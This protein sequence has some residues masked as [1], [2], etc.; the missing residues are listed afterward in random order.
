M[1]SKATD[2]V[3]KIFLDKLKKIAAS[4]PK[5]AVS[6]CRLSTLASKQQALLHNFECSGSGLVDRH[7]CLMLGV[8]VSQ[9][10]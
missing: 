6:T 10:R 5:D 8:R 4:K 1:A 7:E 9:L 2:P 3:Q